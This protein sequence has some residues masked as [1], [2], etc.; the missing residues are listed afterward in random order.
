MKQTYKVI[1]DVLVYYIEDDGV[2]KEFAVKR[3]D[4]IEL[5]D[6]DPTTQLLLAKRKIAIHMTKVK[7][8]KIKE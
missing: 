6:D 5:R 8:S 1:A 4:I 2:R 3:G 7:T